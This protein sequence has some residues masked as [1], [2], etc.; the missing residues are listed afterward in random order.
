MSFI[1]Y[2]SVRWLAKTI[3]DSFNNNYSL[4]NMNKVPFGKK[5]DISRSIVDFDAVHQDI[6]TPVI[7]E[8]GLDPLRAD[9][10]M[11]GGIIHKPMFEL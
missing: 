10:E 7:K 1:K 11:T 3:I 8:S 6:I 2:I 9:E 5:P 4:N